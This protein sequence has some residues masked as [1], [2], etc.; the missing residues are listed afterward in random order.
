L[1]DGSVGHSKVLHFDLL[2]A[3]LTFGAWV[4]IWRVGGGFG[5]RLKM[6]KSGCNSIVIPVEIYTTH[7]QVIFIIFKT[8]NYF[9]FFRYTYLTQIYDKTR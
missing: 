7:Q 1:S 2:F 4:N 8:S 3:A 9:F 6:T 5:G